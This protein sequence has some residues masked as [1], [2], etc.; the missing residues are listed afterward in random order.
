MRE[1]NGVG[2]PR[3]HLLDHPA[4]SHTGQKSKSKSKSKFRTCCNPVQNEAA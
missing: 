1:D 4:A 3:H 2:G